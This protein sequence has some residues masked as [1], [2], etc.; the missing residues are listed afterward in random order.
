MDFFYH[1]DRNYKIT[2]EICSETFLMTLNDQ[3]NAKSFKGT[4]D[5]SVM[6]D[7]I[8]DFE[9]LMK[10]FLQGRYIFRIEREENGM[11]MI[12]EIIIDSMLLKRVELYLEE[13][14]PIERRL[15]I[16]EKAIADIS[17][18]LNYLTDK[19]LDP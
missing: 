4:F 3:R 9:K 8:E 5:M 14:S 13:L 12:F 1:L 11:K 7:R 6:V 18:K 16:M 15:Q 2:L 17:E 10:R 19:S